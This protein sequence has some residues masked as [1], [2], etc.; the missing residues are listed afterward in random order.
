VFILSS[1]QS[2][3][4][5][6]GYVLGS[7]PES[8]FLGEYHRAW[9][10]AIRVPCTLCAA[11]GLPSCEIL[12]NVETEPAGRAFDLAFARTGKRVIVDTSKD[13]EWVDLF[14]GHDDLDIR[15]VHL[16]RDPRGI[17][18]SVKRRAPTD[19]VALVAQWL[20]E[21]EEFRG[22]IAASGLPRVTASYD[23]LAQSPENEFPRL[24]EFCDMKFTR[25]SLSYWNFEHH[26]FAA[27][28][29]SDAILRRKGYCHVPKHFAT[30]DAA[31]YNRNSQTLFHDQRWREALTP[32]ESAAIE[33][34]A[35]VQEL[36]KSLGFALA[37]KGIKLSPPS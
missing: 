33:N 17:F 11:R 13:I 7:G 31:F 27:N 35:E 5:W 20:R 10:E 14:R 26:G 2:G 9:K 8:A 19:P 22:F 24:F 30:G 12:H 37:E 25:K 32:T 15:I 6:T 34:S 4:T 28:G 21:N 18:A 16:V 29:A 1:P 23:L 3:S 36:L